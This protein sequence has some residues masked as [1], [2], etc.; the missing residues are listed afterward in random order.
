[1]QPQATFRDRFHLN[2]NLES[3]EK[4]LSII[5][6]EV[7][8]MEEVSI[9]EHIEPIYK[10]TGTETSC[11]NTLT[12]LDS[13]KWAQT[14]SLTYER[15]SWVDLL[16]AMQVQEK[17]SRAWDNTCLPEGNPGHNHTICY[18]MQK[19]KGCWDLMPPSATRP[20]AVTTVCHLVEIISMLGLVWTEFDMKRST[21]R[22]EGNGYMINS[23]HMPGLGVL[24]RFSQ[25]E[26]PNNKENRIVPCIE[27][28]RLCFGQVPSIF[29]S[30]RETV[31]VS[32]KKLETSLMQI[33][34]QLGERH[35]HQFLNSF[36]RP[37]IFPSKLGPS[38][39]RGLC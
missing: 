32:P 15:C 34:P 31:Q 25:V 36:D 17:T 21:L 1:M 29:D 18:L 13:G 26:R 16:S 28:K 9:H 10:I 14:N 22:A 23:E 6:V 24:T 35:R 3:D 2:N 12:K 37:L 7:I 5:Q 27:L 30:I 20:F 4:L 33:L 8:D 38:R 39:S 11:K 19:R